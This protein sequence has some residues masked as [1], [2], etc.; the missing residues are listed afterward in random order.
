M[1]LLRYCTL[2]VDQ[3]EYLSLETALVVNTTHVVNQE[4]YYHLLAEKIYKIQKDLEQKRIQRLHGGG[5]SS[6]EGIGPTGVDQT[7]SLSNLATQQAMMS[8]G[9]TQGTYNVHIH[10]YTTLNTSE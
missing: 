9:P 1:L 5:S 2:G 6:S 7:A 4:E 3:E 10:N 8:Q